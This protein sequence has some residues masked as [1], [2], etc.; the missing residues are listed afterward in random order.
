MQGRSNLYAEARV[1]LGRTSRAFTLL[2]VVG[3]AACGGDSSGPSGNNNNQGSIS[4]TLSGASL[5][6]AQGGNGSVTATVARGGGFAG[7]V[8]IAIEG[9]PANV[10]ASA[11]PASVGAGATTSTITFTAATGATAG[12]STVTI[13]ASGAGVTDQTRTLTLTVTAATQGGF[14]IAVAP[15]T[16]SVPQGGQGTTL[17][18][19]A[20]TGG[21]NGSVQFSATGAPNGVTVGFN[22]PSTTGN[23][24]NITVGV[25]GA[26]ATGNHAI[27]IRAAASGLA[28]QTATLTLTVT[29]SGGGGGNTTYRACGVS[30]L[31]A[32]FQDGNSPWTA[33][34]VSNNSVTFSLPSGRGGVAYVHS[35]GANSF[36]TVINY[37]TQQELNAGATTCP[38]IPLGKTVN[39]TVAGVGATEFAYVGLGTALAAVQPG[40]SSFSLQNVRDGASDLVAT[41]VSFTVNGTSVVQSANKAII[42]RSI[43]PAANSTLPV[44]DFN[45]AEA[46]DPVPRNLTVNNLGTD[47]LTIGESFVT[48]NFG[49]GVLYNETFA[50]AARQIP[51]IGN[52]Q[53]GD[54]HGLTLSASAA[55]L[56][57]TSTRGVLAYFTASADKTFTFGPAI[58][59]VLVNAAATAPYV[60]LRSQYTIQAEYNSAV[61]INYSQTGG[62]TSRHTIIGFSGPYLG[63]TTALDHTD[64]DF[65]PL[66]GWNNLWGLAAGRATQ[67]SL[68]GMKFTGPGSIGGPLDGTTTFLG[69]RM[70]TITP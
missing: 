41:R 46:F 57:I 21:F 62:G 48:Q 14:T 43:N 37:G 68:T 40:I 27:T 13:R 6:V 30:M 1:F 2:A 35:T 28:D 51:T 54:L 63:G 32:A 11:S 3:A 70:G 18:T 49:T 17:L 61:T 69:T 45:A 10:T 31:F 33:V 16:V 22:P 7:A 58:G 4:L 36:T 38:T 52:A 47:A 12:N 19:L 59:T 64:P 23:G 60:R 9:V 20:R 56:P 67:W 25:G 50:P 8:A 29:P 65:S 34:P 24:T 26:V 15:G 53:S 44:L 5:S 66:N 42:R 55:T 39:G